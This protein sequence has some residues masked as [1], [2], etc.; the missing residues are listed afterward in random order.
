VYVNSA[1]AQSSLRSLARGKKSRVPVQVLAEYVLLSYSSTPE[2]G[3]HD[4]SV[5]FLERLYALAPQKKERL[6]GRPN[7]CVIPCTFLSRRIFVN[8][9]AKYGHHLLFE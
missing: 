3:V 2:P 7:P 4:G 8:D 5:R 6:K 1:I 9:L